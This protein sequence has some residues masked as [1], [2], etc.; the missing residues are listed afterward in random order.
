MERPSKY[1]NQEAFLDMF[2]EYMGFVEFQGGRVY[3][4]D[5]ETGKLTTVIISIAEATELGIFDP[6]API[7]D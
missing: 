7:P 1:T 5:D 4:Q 3:I 6:N 2:S